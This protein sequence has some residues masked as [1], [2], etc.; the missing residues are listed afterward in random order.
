MAETVQQEPTTP[1]AQPQEERTFTQSEMN[2]II[3]DRL[4]RERSKYADYDMLKEKAGQLEEAQQSGNAELKKAIERADRLQAQ[5]DTL[6]QAN[7]VREMRQAVS[8]NTG[9]PAGLLSADTEEAC[10]AQAQAILQ[11]AGASAYPT[12]KDGGEPAAKPTGSA[13]DQFASWAENIL[14]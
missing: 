10:T 4:S 7:A 5:L 2:A 3:Q 11:F 14:K 12:V 1:A 8:L 6:T 13:R 9:V